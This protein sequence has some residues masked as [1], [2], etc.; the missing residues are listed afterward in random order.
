MTEVMKGE[1]GASATHTSGKA[2]CHGIAKLGT[3][4]RRRSRLA[5]IRQDGVD[6]L[7]GLVD[8]LTDLST[9]KNNLPAHEDEQDDLGLHHAVD[10]T[11]K[12]FRFIGGE[13]VMARGKTLQANGELDVAGTNDVLDLEVLFHR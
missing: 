13:S 2:Y 8:L 7:K 3:R 5:E 12:E 10:E 4:G 9:S 11:R 1:T 6:E